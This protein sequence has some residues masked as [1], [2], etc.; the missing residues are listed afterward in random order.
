MLRQFFEGLLRP[1]WLG[2]V[3]HKYVFVSVYFLKNIVS[4]ITMYQFFY[5]KFYEGGAASSARSCRERHAYCL[6]RRIDLTHEIPGALRPLVDSVHSFD[7]D[8]VMKA[9]ERIMSKRAVGKVVI[10]VAEE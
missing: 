7:R 8:G 5:A 9:Y 1:T 10:K 3:P 6:L 2:G 4:E